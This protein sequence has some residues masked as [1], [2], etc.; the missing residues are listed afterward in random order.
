MK[1]MRKISR[2]TGFR[3][4]LDYV[5]EREDGK[6]KGRL[7]GGNLSGLSPKELA[8]EFGSVRRLRPGVKKPVWHNS[9]RLPAGENISDQK[10]NE[11]A[12][13]YM[14]EIGFSDYHPRVYV[15]HDDKNGQHIHIVASRISVSGELYLGQNENLISTRIISELEKKYDLTIT[16][17][18]EKYGDDNEKI[19]QP[20]AKKPKKKEI[21]KSLRTGDKP[22]RQRLQQLIDDVV[23]ERPSAIKFAEKLELAG[24]KVRANVASTGKMNGFSFVFDGVQF[25]GSQLGDKY[26]WSSLLKLGITFDSATDAIGLERFKPKVS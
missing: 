4:V 12:D 23:S 17:G 6:D 20:G 11:F 26:K 2:G 7:I 8:N 1:G 5:F 14:R 18:V 3:G 15:M 19:V 24:V 9:L 13:D 21:E 22:P 10:W 25:S 16:K